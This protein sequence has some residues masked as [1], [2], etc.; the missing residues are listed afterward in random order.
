MKTKWYFGALLIVFTL[1][2][3]C[4]NEFSEPNQEIALNKK[5]TNDFDILFGLKNFN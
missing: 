2:G 5:L 1:L 4:Q 3:V